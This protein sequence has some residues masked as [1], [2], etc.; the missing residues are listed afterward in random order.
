M[1]DSVPNG[2]HMSLSIFEKAVQFGIYMN[3][4]VFNISGGEPTSHPQF[5]EMID[6]MLYMTKDFIPAPGFTIESNG[7]FIRDANKV[8]TVR[9]ILKHDRLIAFQVCSIKGLYK[10]Y[11]FIQKYKKKILA[12]SKKMYVHDTYLRKMVDLGRC[13][14][15]EKCME[16]VKEDPYFMSCINCALVSKQVNS[17]KSFSIYMMSKS[18]SC[19]PL[20]DF[21]GNVHMSESRLCPSVGNVCTDDFDTIWENMRKFKPC[22][23]CHG[24][25]NFMESENPTIK[26]ARRLFELHS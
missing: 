13:L 15:N 22:G 3:T 16:K 21:L 2:G 4:L 9:D 20:I 14:N 5:R 11:N 10:N 7:E 18:Y 6:C 12:M 24:Y 1:Q 26:A 17:P 23:K 19:T 25:K 8:S